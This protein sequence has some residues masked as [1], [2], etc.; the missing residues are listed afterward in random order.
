MNKTTYKPRKGAITLD[1][2]KSLKPYGEKL[3][4]NKTTKEKKTGNRK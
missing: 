1:E 2:S 4:T 3:K